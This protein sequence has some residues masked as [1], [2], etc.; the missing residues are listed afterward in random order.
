MVPVL[1][2]LAGGA[3]AFY[4]IWQFRRWIR[5]TQEAVAAGPRRLETIVDELVATAEAT[6]A[7]VAEKSES[8]VEVLDRADQTVRRLEEATKAALESLEALKHAGEKSAKKPAA[9][10]ASPARAG[11]GRSRAAAAA[12][13]P[14][15]TPPAPTPSAEPPPRELEIQELLGRRRVPLRSQSFEHAGASRHAEPAPLRKETGAATADLPDLHR[16]IY[17]LADAGLDVTDIARQ[18]S[19]TKGEVQLI[20]GLRRMN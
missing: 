14:G 12:K 16:R 11:G 3:V 2:L 6:V 8:V 10:K 17:G 9:P 13:P 1:L 15:G 7:A 18:L 5:E 20:L 19:M 4:G